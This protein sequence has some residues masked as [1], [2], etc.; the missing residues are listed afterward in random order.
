MQR[1][2]WNGGKSSI[3]LELGG[4]DVNYISG[5]FQPRVLGVQIKA[6]PTNDKRISNALVNP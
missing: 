1:K 2:G 3:G 5:A 6:T 4:Q